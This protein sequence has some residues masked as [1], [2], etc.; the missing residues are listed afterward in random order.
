MKGTPGR[1]IRMGLRTRGVWRC[2]VCEKRA[3]TRLRIADSRDTFRS[4]VKALRKSLSNEELSNKSTSRHK[5][6][7]KPELNLIINTSSGSVIC[8]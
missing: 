7:N 3:H 2:Y 4:T 8:S 1:I 6:N 5:F